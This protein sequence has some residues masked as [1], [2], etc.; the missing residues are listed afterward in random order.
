MP[1]AED[2]QNGY[3]TKAVSAGVKPTLNDDARLSESLKNKGAARAPCHEWRRSERQ[4]ALVERQLV[5]PTIFVQDPLDV[6]QIAGAD[7][8]T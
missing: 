4:I 7:H 5:L 3:E 6:G 8:F 2:V 1:R